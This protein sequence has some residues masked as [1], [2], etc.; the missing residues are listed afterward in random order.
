MAIKIDLLQI[1][2]EAGKPFMTLVNIEE[3]KKRRKQIR[4]RNR[5]NWLDSVGRS[6]EAARVRER[7][8]IER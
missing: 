2:Q 4:A 6:D 1:D 5:A 3:A 7:F 8:G